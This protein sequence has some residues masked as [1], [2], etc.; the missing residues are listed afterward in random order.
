MAR[1][2]FYFI[3]LLFITRLLLTI[4]AKRA[5]PTFN[6]NIHCL[7]LLAVVTAACHTPQQA[8]APAYSLTDFKS[9]LWELSGNGL[10][11]PSYLYG[12]IHLIPQRDYFMTDLALQKMQT[13]KQLCLEIDIDDPATNA[14]ALK[15]VMTDGKMLRDIMPAD[16]YAYLTQA[17]ADKNIAILTVRRLKPLLI[18]A[19]LLERTATEPMV[20]Y[21]NKFVAL[22]RTQHKEIVGLESAESQMSLLDSIPYNVQARMLL[23][24][25][26]NGSSHTQLT[27][28]I[29]LYKIQDIDAIH[30]YTRAQ[31]QEV[32]RFECLLLETRNRNW[33]SGIIAKATEKSTF[34]AV[35]AAHLGGENGIIRLLR[36]QGYQVRPLF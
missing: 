30:A 16:D 4:F 35:G 11:K 14:A 5:M 24:E 13:A 9:L 6:P 31:S 10:K 34:F 15:G 1:S 29:R 22:A 23:A 12:T 17:L 27:E 25:L 32:A 28:I 36:Q 26:R 8:T 20:S 7:W 21:E 2:R 18:S 3:L 33:L 19:L